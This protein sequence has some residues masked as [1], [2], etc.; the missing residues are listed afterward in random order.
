MSDWRGR[1][2]QTKRIMN[3]TPETKPSGQGRQRSNS[4]NGGD[5]M[6]VSDEN[7]Q[8]MH[9]QS[10]RA[11][12]EAIS[13]A[14]QQRRVMRHRKFWMEASAGNHA[15][16]L[17]DPRMPAA[18]KCALG[19]VIDVAVAEA[20]RPLPIPQAR[21]A[22]RE[23]VPRKR[24][25]EN[26]VSWYTKDTVACPKCGRGFSTLIDCRE[27]LRHCCW[28]RTNFPNGSAWMKHD[29]SEAGCVKAKNPLGKF[30]EK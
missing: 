15:R 27:H 30:W 16:T 14:S 25:K 24:R 18:T 23:A 28:T 2:S 3:A 10:R 26:P 13:S 6:Q 5:Q 8:T 4:T 21:Q 19:E 1:R 12:I 17:G 20:Q 9:E 29:N 11:R 7:L 22:N